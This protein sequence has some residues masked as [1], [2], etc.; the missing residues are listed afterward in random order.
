[1]SY[2]RSSSLDP[3]DAMAFMLGSFTVPDHDQWKTLFESDELGRAQ[4]FRGLAETGAD[5]AR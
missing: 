1:V 5:D 3:E 4:E 2:A